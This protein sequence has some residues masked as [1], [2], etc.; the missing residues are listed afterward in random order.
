MIKQKLT[1]AKEYIVLSVQ[2]IVFCG[3]ILAYIP[4]TTGQDLDVP[5]V[6]TPNNVVER[7]LD[8]TDV[9]PSDYV[10]DL[11]SGDGR[12]VIAAA[13][14]GASGHGIDLDP[15]RIAEARE[16]AANAGVTDQIMFMEQDIFETDFSEASVIT[17]YLLPSVNKQ[18]RP[19]LLDKLQPG[20]EIVSHSFDMGEWEPDK[21]ISVNQNGSGT[22]QIYYWVIPA[23]ANGSWSW[24]HNGRQ[25]SM[26]IDQQFQ[27]ISVDISD[28]T[29][30][31]FDIKKAQL[32]GKRIT[33]RA[34]SGSQNYIYSGRIEGD[35]IHG[36]MQNHNGEE[37]TF[38][39]WSATKK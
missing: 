6:P 7:M 37:K 23:K 4:D 30:S 13:K 26:D 22:H 24:S 3:L 38:S 2:T 28:A 17:M 31:S 12:I 35:Q 34:T 8:V 29:G 18:L 39:K 10:I 9:Q 20:T 5:Y 1:S 33:I 25:Y 27:E 15:Q 21:E 36:M 19:D 14:R 11:G 16:N 32:Q